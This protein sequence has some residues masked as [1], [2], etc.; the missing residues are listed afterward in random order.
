MRWASRPRSAT[1]STCRLAAGHPDDRAARGATSRGR[2]DASPTSTDTATSSSSPTTPSTTS[3]SS[4]PSIARRGRCERSICDLKD[5]GLANLPSGRFALNEVWL[6]LV[7][8][9]SDLLAWMKGLCLEGALAK[10]EP[11]RLRYTLLH[12][13]GIIVRSARRSTVRI[14]RAG[15]G[16]T[17]SSPRSAIARLDQHPRLTSLL[18]LR[19]PS[20]PPWTSTPQRPR[21]PSDR[22]PLSVPSRHPRRRPRH[23]GRLTTERPQAESSSH[24]GAN[25]GRAVRRE[26]DAVVALWPSA[27]TPT[28]PGAL[29]TLTRRMVAARPAVRAPRYRVAPLGWD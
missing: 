15:R 1:W 13:A 29:S 2:V 20:L 10:A 23:R 3:P 28:Q 4:K 24:G 19:D 7:L 26:D 5:T 18:R 6:T 12:T 16:P 21:R 8:I 11:K 22:R 14:A 25:R 27:T 9:A 17:T